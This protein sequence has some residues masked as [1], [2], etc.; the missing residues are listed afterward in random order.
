MH[1]V[2]MKRVL[3]L[4]MLGGALSAC[5]QKELVD[6]GQVAIAQRGTLP[7]PTDAD[8]LAGTRAE[9]VG[10][11]DVLAVDVFGLPEVSRQVRVDAS[12]S[13]A[14]PLAGTIAVGGMSPEQIAR[15]IEIKLQSSFVRDP[16][17]TVGIVE[18]VSR[19]VT[20]EGE[21]TRPGLYPVIGRSTL[22][23]AIAR[24][25]GTSDL[26][27]PRHVVIFRT[28]DGRQMAA[29]YDL[30]AIRLGAY[31][32]P[33]VYANDVVVVGESKARALL[34][35]IAQISSVL[36]TPLIYILQ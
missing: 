1:S 36:L 12:G 11:G 2:A 7:A 28:V 23:R 25:E 30:R 6:T 3:W 8:M 35:Q 15:A 20:V 16:R 10:P 32:D 27:D 17:V 18:M 19:V 26:A 33:E 31:N 29:L 34:P 9:V 4:W 13:I 21:V 24:A 5:G 14:V 22:M